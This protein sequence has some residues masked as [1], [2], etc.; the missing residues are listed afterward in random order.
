M[1]L[2]TPFGLIIWAFF[3]KFFTHPVWFDQKIFNI[4]VVYRTLKINVSV[5]WI[6]FNPFAKKLPIFFENSYL[7][8]NDS[9]MLSNFWMDRTLVL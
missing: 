1:K 6:K 8:K 5:Q 3:E 7:A 4:L 2:V 9:A